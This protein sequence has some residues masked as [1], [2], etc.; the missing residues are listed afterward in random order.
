MPYDFFGIL[1]CRNNGL[2]GGF[3]DTIPPIFQASTIPCSMS[4]KKSIP[5]FPNLGKLRA[6]SCRCASFLQKARSEY[7]P[8]SLCELWRDTQVQSLE[9]TASNCRTRLPLPAVVASRQR[10]LSPVGRVPYSGACDTTETQAPRTTE[11]ARPTISSLYFIRSPLKIIR[12]AC[13]L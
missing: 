8:P 11:E 1:E 12:R 4:T 9:E 3:P 13:G 10:S 2:L 5:F 7:L 6:E